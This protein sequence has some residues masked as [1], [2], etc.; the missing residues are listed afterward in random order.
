MN[1]FRLRRRVPWRWKVSHVERDIL[2]RKTSTVDIY[3]IKRN[4][5]RS[6]QHFHLSLNIYL[7]KS[8]KGKR[9]LASLR[10]RRRF[11]SILQFAINSVNFSTGGLPA[12]A[13][14]LNVDLWRSLTNPCLCARSFKMSSCKLKYGRSLLRKIVFTELRLFCMQFERKSREAEGTR[15]KKGMRKYFPTDFSFDKFLWGSLNASA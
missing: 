15:G 5:H 4:F 12:E 8:Q 2:W 14:S 1:Q 9:K 7:I 11:R 3:D 6:H 13:A 10:R